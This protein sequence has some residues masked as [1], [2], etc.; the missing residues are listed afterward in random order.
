MPKAIAGK[1]PDS[2]PSR[3][4]DM[5]S[6]KR[7]LVH[8]RRAPDRARHPARA[9]SGGRGRSRLRGDARG[10]RCGLAR[11][12]RFDLGLLDLRLGN[13]RETSIPAARALAGAGTPFMFLT[14]A[15]ADAAEIAVFG[16][17][18]L[19]KPFMPHADGDRAKAWRGVSQRSGGEGEVEPQGIAALLSVL[20]LTR[21]RALAI[22]YSSLPSG[23]RAQLVSLREL[24]RPG[25]ESADRLR[26]DR[27]DAQS[28][29]P[30][31]C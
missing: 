29:S 3:V 19:E 23:C 18:I 30:Q 25:V 2:M 26:D 21:S 14:G 16:R 5:L 4:G 31:N 6:G 17:P 20:A 7:C 12:P 1:P 9:G 13:S 11:W 22:P 10:S 24:A 8:R 27:R 28:S 15:A